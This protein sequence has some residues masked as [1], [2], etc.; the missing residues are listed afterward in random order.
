MAAAAGATG[1]AKV[2]K[3][4]TLMKLGGKSKDKW[5][6]RHFTLS[7]PAPN[8]ETRPPRLPRLPTPPR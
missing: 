5:E 2:L 6:E 4:G 8:F 3:E 1:G 7:A